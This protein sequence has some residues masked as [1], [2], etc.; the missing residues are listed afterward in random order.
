M[1]TVRSLA[2]TALF[3]ATTAAPAMGACRIESSPCYPWRIEAGKRETLL[4]EIVPN[5]APTY[6]LYRICL[7]PPAKEVSLVF[8]FEGKRVELGALATESDGAIC[9][10]YRLATARK[11]RLLL[12]R[13]KADGAVMEGCYTT[14]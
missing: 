11:S 6:A 9:R 1:P 7:C 5:N 4:L 8:D 10:D 12:R 2:L 14:Q 3:V 13:S